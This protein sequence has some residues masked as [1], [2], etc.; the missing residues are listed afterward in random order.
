[1]K[2]QE[3]KNIIKNEIRIALAE[4][5]P[6]V[7]PPKPGTKTPTKPGKPGL[8]PDKDKAPKTRPKAEAKPKTNEAVSKGIADIVKKYKSLKKK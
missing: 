2:L 7:A 3:L 6:A 8:I 1:M 5:A 4:N